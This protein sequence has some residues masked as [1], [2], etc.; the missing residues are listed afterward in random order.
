MHRPIKDAGPTASQSQSSDTILHFVSKKNG[1]VR[2]CLGADGK[3]VYC[4]T[5]KTL[6]S[7]VLETR[8]ILG[9]DVKVVGV[10][11]VETDVEDEVVE[12]SAV[13]WAT[14]NEKGVGSTAN[15]VQ[16]IVRIDWEH[17]DSV[18]VTGPHKLDEEDIEEIGPLLWFVTSGKKSDMSLVSVPC[19][20]DKRH[21]PLGAFV[22]KISPSAVPKLEKQVSGSKPALV[23]VQVKVRRRLTFQYNS[24][25]KI[26]CT[27]FALHGGPERTTLK[28]SL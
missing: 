4:G 26:D 17:V 21:F 6:L 3:K 12:Q 24:K 7:T 22:A 19:C 11:S 14:R 25:I 13:I 28:S 10:C 23:P 2:F 15:P 8:T 20:V 1:P 9:S 16:P 18:V 5:K 27:T